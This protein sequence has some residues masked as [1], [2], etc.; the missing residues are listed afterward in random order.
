MSADRTPLQSA[1]KRVY[2]ALCDAQEYARD[3]MPLCSETSERHFCRRIETDI[4]R[5]FQPVAHL[6]HE[7]DCE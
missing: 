7:D 2:E 6:M 5:L 4:E 3:A 1:A